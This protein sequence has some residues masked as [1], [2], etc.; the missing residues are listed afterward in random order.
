MIAFLVRRTLLAGVT[1]TAISIVAFLSIQLPPGDFATTYVQQLLGF[2]QGA[3]ATGNILGDPAIEAQIREAY[4]LD[5]PVIIQYLKWLWRVLQLD[6]GI[7]L[8]AQKKITEII[9]Q[10]LLNTVLLALGT[11]LFTWVLAVPI[12]IY[13]A[14]KHNTAGDYAVTFVGF[15]GLA[16]PDFLLAL[17][18]MWIGFFYFDLSVGGLYSPEY[19]DA[20]WSLGRVWDLLAHLWIPAIVLGTAGTAGLIRILRNNLL[21]ELAKP[22]VVTARSKGLKGWRVVIKYPVRVALNPFISGIGQILPALVSGSVIVSVVLSLPTLGPTLLNAIF[23]Q[24][25]YVAGLIILMLGAL[26]VIGT[27]ISDLLLVVVDPRIKLGG[28]RQSTY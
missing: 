19:L 23:R 26:T 7:G 6:F 21:D 2:G 22:Y 20:P 4:G 16:V 28:Q 25:M 24:D 27:L 12:G 8:E 15:L 11:V 1:T 5:R 13:S 18:L 10:R 14:V 3:G 9:G 17:T